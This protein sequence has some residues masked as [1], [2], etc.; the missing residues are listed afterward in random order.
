MGEINLIILTHLER[1]GRMA[2]FVVMARGTLEA[3]KSISRAKKSFEELSALFKAKDAK[4][5][6]A[7]A[8]LGHYDLMFITEAPDLA[9]AFEL[10]TM[11]GT[12]GSLESETYPILPL[13][14]L[15]EM[16]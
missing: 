14:E 2:R 7:Y 15:Y 10:A 5:L 9:T 1:G 6:N 11:I 4:I 12:Q 16:M 3:K 8:V 13:E